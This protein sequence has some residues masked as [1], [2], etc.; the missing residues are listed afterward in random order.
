MKRKKLKS[1]YYTPERKRPKS[2]PQLNQN[3]ITC[4]FNQE[5]KNKSKMNEKVLKKAKR[6]IK[7][8]LIQDLNQEKPPRKLKTA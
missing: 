3:L 7:K 8:V 5:N 1:K 2:K 4:Q 6:K